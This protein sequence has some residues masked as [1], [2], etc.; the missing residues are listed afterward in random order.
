[1]SSSGK[2]RWRGPISRCGLRDSADKLPEPEELRAPLPAQ[3][4]PR[5]PPVSAALRLEFGHTEPSSRTTV[6]ESVRDAFGDTGQP[7]GRRRRGSARAQGTR[8]RGAPGQGCAGAPARGRAER[9]RRRTK[10][11]GRA[12]RERGAAALGRGRLLLPAGSPP[13]KQE[14]LTSPNKEK[15]VKKCR[16]IFPHRGLLLVRGHLIPRG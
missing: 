7:S 3:P 9:W 4:L 6:P 1:M 10:G 16:E 15:R 8:S 5:R 12:G 14:V 11:R 13:A 2:G